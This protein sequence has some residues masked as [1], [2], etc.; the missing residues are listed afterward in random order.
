MYSSTYTSTASSIRSEFSGPE[1][2][3]FAVSMIAGLDIRV[4]LYMFQG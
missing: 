3:P 4:M 2:Q 1:V